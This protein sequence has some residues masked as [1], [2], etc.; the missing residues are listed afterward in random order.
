MKIDLSGKIAVVTGATGQLGRTMVRSL[1]ECG[2]D[3]VL[4]YHNNQ[5][6]AEQLRDEIAAAWSVR[7]MAVT[8]L[9]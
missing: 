5:A 8:L 1:A 7:A 2:A 4:C 3:V 6:F 9:N